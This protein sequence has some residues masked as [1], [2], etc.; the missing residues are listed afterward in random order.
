M[1][2]RIVVGTFRYGGGEN[3]MSELVRLTD[4][5]KVYQGGLTGALNGISVSI[6]TGEFTAIMGP[7]GSGQSTMLN[8][9]ARL[10]RPAAGTMAVGRTDLGKV[11]EPGRAR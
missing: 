5:T 3:G 1:D 9:V 10:D 11:G 6:E 8:L 4:V 7:S 2:G